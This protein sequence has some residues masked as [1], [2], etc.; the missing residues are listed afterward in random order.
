MVLSYVVWCVCGVMYVVWCVCGVVWW[1]VW[2][3][4]VVWC[5]VVCVCDPCADK[6][7]PTIIPKTT[8]IAV[9]S[10][11]TNMHRFNADSIS[12]SADLGAFA[13]TYVYSHV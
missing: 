13:E 7:V 6:S 11:F 12:I 8:K 2:C 9:P 3:M 5:G 4:Y 10:D 1:C